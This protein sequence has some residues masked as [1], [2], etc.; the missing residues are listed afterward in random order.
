[1]I[2]V[3]RKILLVVLAL[4]AV[5]LATP[6][7]GMVSAIPGAEKNNDKFEFFQLVVS[8]STSGE[9]DKIWTNPPDVLPP[10]TVHARGGGWITG[11]T[12]ELTIGSVTYTKTS[13]PVRVDYSTTFDYNG[14]LKDGVPTIKIRLLDIVTVY[15][16]DVAVGTL[17]LKITAVG[18]P[19]G[20]SGTI[21]GY[22]TEAFEG[23]HISAIDS[24]VPPSYVRIGTIQGWPGLP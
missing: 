9:F 6:Y 13:S 4:A 20:Y 3:N 11:D 10:I 1:V 22:G 24:V 15:V 16:N 21:V 18:G 8:G 14:V 2:E 23:V 7:I 17:V 5:L 12:I 19:S